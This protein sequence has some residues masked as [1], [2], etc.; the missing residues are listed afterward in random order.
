MEK[1]ALALIFGIKK[2]HKC[3]FGLLFTLITDHKPL[4]SIL[5]AKT[6]VPSVAAAHMQRWAIFLSAYTYN[7][8]YKG[9]KKHANAD[10][11]P[12]LQVQGEEDQDATATAMFK[13]SSSL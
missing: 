11:L 6:V 7:I 2:I 12:H 3:I 1:E 13:V 9:T 4:L 10:S 5:N 8:E